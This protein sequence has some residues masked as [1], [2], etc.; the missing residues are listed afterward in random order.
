M[1]FNFCKWQ[2]LFFEKSDEPHFVYS[3]FSFTSK[4]KT[5][6]SNTNTSKSTTQPVFADI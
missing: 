5:K 4:H 2:N 1:S 3:S 6:H